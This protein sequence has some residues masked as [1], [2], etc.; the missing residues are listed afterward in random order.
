[1]QISRPKK[2][3]SKAQKAAEAAAAEAEERRAEKMRKL[4]ADLASLST[5]T[6]KS[7]VTKSNPTTKSAKKIATKSSGPTAL[8]EDSDFG[9]ETELS[10]RELAEKAQR[11]KTLRFYTSQIAQKLNRRG[12]AGRDAGGDMDIPHRERFRERQ[13]RDAE[14]RGKKDDALDGAAEDLSGDDTMSRSMALP[15]G[16]GDDEDYYDMVVAQSK[17]KKADKA[18]AA[19]AYSQAKKVGGRVVQE[20]TVGEDKKRRITYAIEKNKGITP[21]R[22]K[23]VRNPRVKKR[24]KYKE[25]QKKLA[26]VRQI[27]KGGE[28]KGGY[29]GELTGI[30][31]GLVKSVKL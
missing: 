12:L 29:G 2:K 20:E 21:S 25:K 22:R 4:E 14:R 16:D 30:K 7:L 13:A 5:L 11:K 31:T 15:N 8:E 26:S 10:T 23:E 28:G 19:Q 9:D 17:Q 1:L 24:M 18:A 6:A 3:K 27:Y